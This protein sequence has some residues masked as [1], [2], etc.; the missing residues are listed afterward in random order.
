[1]SNGA[2]YSTVIGQD[3]Y[4][5]EFL[6]K[7]IPVDNSRHSQKIMIRQD[8]KPVMRIRIRSDWHNFAGSGTVSI[9]S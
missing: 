7:I 9:F 6:P 4:F 1:M 5:K 8:S 2:D 3:R